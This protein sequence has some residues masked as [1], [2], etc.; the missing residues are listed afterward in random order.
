VDPVVKDSQLVTLVLECCRTHVFQ[1]WRTSSLNQ[2]YTIAVKAWETRHCCNDLSLC[3][4]RFTDYNFRNLHSTQ[5]VQSNLSLW[6]PVRGAIWCQC[7]VA[8]SLTIW[9]QFWHTVACWRKMI[10]KLLHSCSN[11]WRMAKRL[12]MWSVVPSSPN[13]SACRLGNIPVYG[14]CFRGSFLELCC[15]GSNHGHLNVRQTQRNREIERGG[16]K[17]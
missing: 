15:L 5:M 17:D 8:F 6:R 10:G 1:L 14:L 16:S 11:L 13:L 2:L 7:S 4:A 9:L 12:S 3:R